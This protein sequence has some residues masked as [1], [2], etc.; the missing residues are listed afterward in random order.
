M[1]RSDPRARS[2]EYGSKIN[3]EHSEILARSVPYASILFASLLPVLPMATGLPLLP[4]LGLIVFLAWRMLRPGL[5]P[6]W[7]GFPLGLFDDL[8]SGQP[9]GSGILLWSLTMIA[10]EALDIQFRWRDFW[11]DWLSVGAIL[12]VYILAAAVLS[13][14]TLT[15]PGLVALAPQILFSIMAYPILARIVSRLD[16]FRLM[17]IKVV[18]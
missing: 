2:D 14:A 1:E 12:A 17:R 7:V 8:Y 11:L 3:R 5:L 15:T 6:M 4:P 13:G 16:R 9:F 18:G 10:V